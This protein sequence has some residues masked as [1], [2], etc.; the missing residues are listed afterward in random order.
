MVPISISV[1]KVKS[2]TCAY[3]PDLISRYTKRQTTE[4]KSLSFKLF[5]VTLNIGGCGVSLPFSLR[6]PIHFISISFP[7]LSNKSIFYIFS[8]RHLKNI[9]CNFC[10]FKFLWYSLSHCISIL[11]CFSIPMYFYSCN[12]DEPYNSGMW[13]YGSF[14]TKEFWRIRFIW[15]EFLY[16]PW[17]KEKASPNSLGLPQIIVEDFQYEVLPLGK[18]LCVHPSFSDS[19]V[20][21]MLYQIV[22]HQFPVFFHR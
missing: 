8:T 9:T 22:I 16:A 19:C 4:N 14:E 6:S 21:H 5:L 2:C 11:C 7:S 15:E 13:F 10:V 17:N 18:F 3:T 20:F 12:P 1:Y